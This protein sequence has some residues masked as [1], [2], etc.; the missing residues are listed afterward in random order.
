M[1]STNFHLYQKQRGQNYNYIDRVLKSYIMQG[2]GIFYLYPMVAVVGS[3]NVEHAIGENGLVVSDAVLNENPKR[4]YSREVFELWGVTQMKAPS[5]QYVLAGLTDADSD[6]KQ[7]ILHYNSMIAQIGRKIIAG[8]VIEITW[9]RDLDVL[10][11]D[12]AQNKFYQV[13]T[14]QR[15]DEAWDPNYKYHLWELKIKPLTASP[16]FS[17]L[18]NTG[19]END[20]YEDYG[21]ANGGGGLS[22]ENT[23]SSNELAIMDSILDEAEENGPSFRLHDEHHVYLDE[24]DKLYVE[25]LFV[26]QGTDG[27]PN[28]LNCTDIV[29]GEEFPESFEED[30]YFLRTDYNPPRLYKRLVNRWQLVEFDNREKWTG[31]PAILRSHINNDSTFINESDETVKSQQNIKDL[32]KARI[33]KEN[34]KSRD[35]KKISKIRPDDVP[36]GI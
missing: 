19:E 13:T 15:Y 2:G 27:I 18:Y 8:D 34:G 10:G 16:E 3:D 30:G 6:E 29:F 25:N 21:S 28:Q 5:W 4:K 12:K 24:N 9:L 33:K 23:T 35:W 17:D 26:P 1:G 7:L 32:V 14:S 31:C 11:S 22:Q 20:F 36:T